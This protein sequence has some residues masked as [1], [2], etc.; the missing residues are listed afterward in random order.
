MKKTIKNIASVAGI[1][2][3]SLFAI[4]SVDDGSGQYTASEMTS[5]K[6]AFT[7]TDKVIA[8]AYDSN[9][10]AADV[11]YKGKVG[12]VTGKIIDISNDF[13][14]ITIILDGTTFTGVC[15]NLAPAAKDQ[16]LALKTGQ[17]VTVKGNCTGLLINVN[18]EDGVIVTK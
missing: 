3:F 8:K 17:V 18:F 15:V 11:Q 14:I 4:A 12:E 6:S 1:G 9:E 10:V 7:V 13:D 5:T 16:V 2:I